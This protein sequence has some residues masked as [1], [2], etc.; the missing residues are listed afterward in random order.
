MLSSGEALLLEHAA[1]EHRQLRRRRTRGSIVLIAAV[2][3]A[4]VTVVVWRSVTSAREDRLI[5]VPSCVPNGLPLF[6]NERAT[7]DGARLPG[8]TGDTNAPYFIGYSVPQRSVWVGSVEPGTGDYST[9]IW[10]GTSVV[11][12]RSGVVAQAVEVD[13]PNEDNGSGLIWRDR[14]GLIVAVSGRN[15]DFATVVQMANTVRFVT[16]QQWRDELTGATPGQVIDCP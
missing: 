14:S 16:E 9:E 7:E 6:Q 2:V 12:L 5:A 4:A 10:Q 8:T 11:T 15:V 3:V 1:V 13:P